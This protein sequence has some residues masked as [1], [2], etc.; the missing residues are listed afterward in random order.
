MRRALALADRFEAAGKSTAVVSV[1]TPKPLDRPGLVEILKSF[2]H[3]VVIEECAPNGSVA[4]RIKEIAFEM[5][6]QCRID[7]FTLKDSF[8]HCY[9][10][11]D[12]ILDAHGLSVA[13]I[14]GR[15]RLN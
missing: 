3:V 11:H 15:V 8:I 1:H 10:S 7:A 5:R 4:M 9:G 14:A 13:E 2:S 6:A 12:D